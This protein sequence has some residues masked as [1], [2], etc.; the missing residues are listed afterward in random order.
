MR[1]VF[2]CLCILLASQVLA[3]EYSK[4]I[5]GIVQDTTGLPL[6]GVNI[7]LTSKLDTLLTTTGSDGQFVFPKVIDNEYRVTYSLLGYQIQDHLYTPSKWMGGFEYIVMKL[8]PQTTLLKEVNVYGTPPIQIKGDTVQYNA[9]AYH[10]REGALLEA[11]M[12]EFPGVTVDRLGNVRSQG[13]LITRVKVNG[14][15]FFG[16]DVLTATRNLPAEIVAN[17]QVI[18]D[19][20]EKAAFTGIKDTEPEKIVNITLKKDK[21]H[22]VFGQVT[23]GA[24]SK[25]RYIGSISANSFNEK[26]QISFIGSTNNTNAS[27]YS[28]GDVS[29]AG[30]S[31]DRSG[32]DLNTIIN[33]DDGINRVNSL[34][35]NY[36]DDISDHLSTY[37][38]YVFTNR[39]NQT[40]GVNNI[41]S[42]FQN[43]VISNRNELTSNNTNNLHKLNWVLESDLSERTY[44]KVSPGLS[45]SR[46][47]GDSKNL[48]K[49]RNQQQS[50][51]SNME[52]DMSSHSP[53]VD[54]EFF[55]NHRFKKR[56]RNFSL[57]VKGNASGMEKRDDIVDYQYRVDS[58]Y[59]D[60]RIETETVTQ[61]IE[62]DQNSRS[63]Q[64][65]ASYI[66]PFNKKSYLELNYI[67]NY[68][69][70]DNLRTT[71]LQ[72]INSVSGQQQDS[73]HMEYA[74]QFQSNQ[75]GF[76]YQYNYK[77]ISY[78]VGFAAQPIYM[79]GHTH[80]L[81]VITEKKDVNLIP[82]FR[83]SYKVD[84]LSTLSLTYQGRTNQPNIAQIQ[85]F[86]DYTNNQNIINGNP[87]LQPEFTNRFSIQ[88]KS[89]NL[90][91]G[92][93]FFGN[94]AFKS[95]QNK[96]VTD[97]VS[98]ANSTRQETGFLNT[99][100]YFDAHAYYLYSLAVIENSLN[101]SLSGSVDYNNNLSYINHQ[102]NSGRNLVFSQ[103]LQTNYKVQDWF[104]IDF[105]GTYS[106]NRI[107]NSLPS[108]LNNQASSLLM[109]LG[110]KT[111]VRKWMFSFDIAQQY[112]N[113]FSSEI[114][115][116]P[117]TIIN[118]FLQRSFL[119]ND[120]AVIRLQ[121]FDLLNMNSGISSEVMGSQSFDSR[122]N[123]LARYFL[124]SFNLR[125]QKFP[126]SS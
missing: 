21:N 24:G 11:L 36:R 7:R 65:E 78:M 48:R 88:Y 34:G 87:D 76:N 52:S 91:S 53:T 68:T 119:K 2:L 98:I 18:D 89:F 111:Y 58:S 114:D 10:V 30:S 4:E 69:A 17:V 23:A 123:R 94:L 112:N 43:N 37:G 103:G 102:K 41:Y 107:R 101:I 55:L 9:E 66:E 63:F 115:E 113:G 117:L 8:I 118:F 25:D 80:N 73:L 77:K 124:L 33:S 71:L 62:N 26:E 51:N 47:S 27:L 1:F 3:Q 75:M 54:M 74:Y 5:R 116:A 13:E 72:S 12:Q 20:G 42:I 70:N 14:K 28:F 61:F 16:G 120:R 83:F 46:G 95:I 126:T 38:G 97:R 59:T 82:S 109:G 31:R 45:Y 99:Q 90:R 81:D 60:P 35:F 15:E 57:T 49:I 96:I 39:N 50:T 67:Y 29:G 125:L 100:G 93:A 122:T 92:N 84:N 44:V 19:Y 64:T 6:E 105:R 32:M 40:Q 86:R 79:S 85:P 108:L 106:L 56:G 104:E 22:G 110:G 121:A